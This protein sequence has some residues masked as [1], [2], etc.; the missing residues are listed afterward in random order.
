MKSKQAIYWVVLLFALGA[1]LLAYYVLQSRPPT[2]PSGP[3]DLETIRM[4]LDSA[5]HSVNSTMAHQLMDMAVQAQTEGKL[6]S[7]QL[8]ALD[9]ATAQATIDDMV[10][11]H[12]LLTIAD[13]ISRATKD[14]PVANREDVRVLLSK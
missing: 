2:S 6:T 13:P 14:K 8:H 7:E 1:I 11:D 3:V 12:E 10:T 5:E 4:R 9:Q